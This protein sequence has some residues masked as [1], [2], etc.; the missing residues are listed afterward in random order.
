MRSL[1]CLVFII[2]LLI[3]GVALSQGVGPEIIN[4]KTKYSPEGEMPA[5]QFPHWYHQG[6]SEC[7]YCHTDD[8]SLY[9]LRTGEPLTVRY[10]A[11]FHGNFCWSCHEAITSFDIYKD[12]VYC[13]SGE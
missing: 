9:N 8:L 10:A 2:G 12:C 1:F 13:H 3:V 6:F 11:D 7:S 5:V 4:L